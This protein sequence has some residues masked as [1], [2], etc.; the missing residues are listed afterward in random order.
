MKKQE[1]YSTHK[2]KYTNLTGFSIDKTIIS[3]QQLQKAVSDVIAIKK[4][5]LALRSMA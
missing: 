1:F 5:F 4:G 2:V 3:T